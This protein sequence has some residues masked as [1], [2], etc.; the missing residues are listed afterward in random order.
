MEKDLNN[1]PEEESRNKKTEFIVK[2]KLGSGTFGS[3]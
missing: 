2:S 1:K 3:V